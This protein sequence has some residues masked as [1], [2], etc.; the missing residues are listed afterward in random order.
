MTEFRSLI[1]QGNGAG[2]LGGGPFLPSFLLEV[3]VW[4]GSPSALS[5][6]VLGVALGNGGQKDQKVLLETGILVTLECLPQTA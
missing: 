1:S 5:G 6:H 4:T 3:P 2:P